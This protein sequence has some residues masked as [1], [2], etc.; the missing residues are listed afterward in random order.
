MLKTFKGQVTFVD[1]IAALMIFLVIFSAITSAWNKQLK[2]MN[3]QKYF[4]SMEFTGFSLMEYLLSSPGS[5][6]NWEALAPGDVNKVGLAEEYLVIDENKLAA[7]EALGADYGNAKELLRTGAF[8]FFFKVDGK[9][10]VNVG[11]MPVGE[12]V[13]FKVRRVAQYKGS[14]ANVE[15][16][17]YKIE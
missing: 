14:E 11:L 2:D 17:L 16:L 1:L 10:D 12:A 8:E 4:D 6:T 7:F 15:L 3:R 13:T 5:P 9:E